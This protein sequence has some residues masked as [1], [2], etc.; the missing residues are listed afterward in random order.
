MLGVDIGVCPCPR[1]GAVDWEDTVL[2]FRESEGV[3]RSCGLLVRQ[4]T[5]YTL[6]CYDE[7][8]NVLPELGEK[9]T[10]DKAALV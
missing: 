5:T 8:G 4:V 2:E 1:C 6:T 3:C 10:R 9:M 7:N